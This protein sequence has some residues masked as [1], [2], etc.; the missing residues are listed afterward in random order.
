MEPILQENPN[1][2]VLFPIQNDAVWQMYK[3]A[4]ASFWTAE[5]IDLTQDNKD[6]ERLND[7]ERHFISHV[8]AFFAA[9]DGIVNENLAINFMQEV[10]LPEA[11]CF[12]GFQIMMENIHSETYSLLIDTYI[13]DPQEK[14]R[15]FNALE[16]VPC[17]KE[18]GEWAL[19]W[20][21]SENFT[22]RLIAFAAVEGI[23][24]SGSFCSIFWMK[25]RG[26]MP[27]LTFSNELISRD[28]GLHCDFACLLYSMLE[29]KLPEE[30]VQNIIRDAVKIEQEFVTDALPVDLIGMNAKL[31]SQYIEFV[32]D[33][34]L[35]SLGCGK[36]YNSTNP[37]DF[38]ELISLQGKTNFFEKRVGDYQ[39]ASVMADK[40]K[41]SFSLDEDF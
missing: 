19:K 37:F 14:D 41:Q 34:L 12:Y 5:E 31:M 2:F 13:K 18:K 11:R 16:T 26:L 28:E 17:V 38:M 22:E 39:K 27:G 40:D 23:F 15:L 20:I 8:L 36:V 30:R 32:A 29:N 33:R 6:W 9:S 7:G 3:K 4:E 24:F 10:Q 35:V 25:K 21:N 1:R